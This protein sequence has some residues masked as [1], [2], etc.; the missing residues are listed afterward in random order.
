MRQQ[1]MDV[2]QVASLTDVVRLSQFLAAAGRDDGQRLVRLANLGLARN[3]DAFQLE[4]GMMRPH[5]LKGT[6]T[7]FVREDGPHAERA[8]LRGDT[9]EAKESKASAMAAHS[10]L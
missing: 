3:T 10:W 7:L 8:I 1:P 2:P 5:R 4:H 9:L 6:V